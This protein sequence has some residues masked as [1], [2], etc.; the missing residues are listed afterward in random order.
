MG[1]F[2][3]LAFASAF[4]GDDLGDGAEAGVELAFDD[5]ALGFMGDGEVEPLEIVF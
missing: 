1:R 2:P 4:D 3:F 5:T